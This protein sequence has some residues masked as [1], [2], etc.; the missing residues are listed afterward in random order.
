M[1][2]NFNFNTI[3]AFNKQEKLMATEKTPPHKRIQRAESGRDEWKVKATA[4]REEIEK[5]KL[6]IK[7][8]EVKLS[9]LTDQNESKKQKLIEV[10]KEMV[11]MKKE[12]ETL[13]KKC[14]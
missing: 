3:I 7:S 8:Y 9:D 12:V 14:S 10:E 13:K 4:R 5:L 1:S 6:D 2:I 11:R